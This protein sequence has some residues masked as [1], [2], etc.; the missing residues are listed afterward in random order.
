MKLSF[1]TNAFIRHSVV[2]AVEK[3]AA[4]G[5]QGVELLADIPHLYIHELRDEDIRDLKNVLSRTGIRVSN[6]NS[7]TVRGYCEKET[8]NPFF[9]PV[10]SSPD[11]GIRKWRIE[12]TK[13]CID[14]ALNL[15]CPNISLTSGPIMPESTPEESLFFFK[16]S[17]R[18]IS[19]YAQ[20]KNIKVGIE[21]EPGLL[22][23]YCVELAILLEE[24]GSTALGAN[25][26]LGHSHLLGE[27]PEVVIKTLSGKIFHIHLEDIRDRVHH[28]L[29]PGLGDMDFVSLFSLMEKYS[30]KGFVTV[31]LY[32][33]PE[34]PEEAAS[35]AFNYLNNLGQKQT[36]KR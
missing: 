4:I 13:R 23:E 25:L 27:D 32:T 28:H 16:E 17:L 34:Q 22:I 5:Y 31:E 20:S 14:L 10:L 21:Y 35:Q 15:N 26:D 33:Y 36:G 30:Y 7:N 19:R 2:E 1:S 8:W 11:P 12:Y 24:I 3:I 18:E 9:E 29:I 6:I